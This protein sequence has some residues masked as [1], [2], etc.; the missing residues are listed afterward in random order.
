M[1]SSGQ[2]D[3]GVVQ[4]VAEWTPFTGWKSW[5][6][7]PEPVW[8]RLRLR[9]GNGDAQLP[10]IAHLRPAFLDKLTLY[11]PSA[12]LIS[13]AGDTVPMTD[14]IMGAITFTFRVPELAQ[15]RELY[16]RVASTSARVVNADVLTLSEARRQVRL[17]EWL[18]GFATSMSFIFALWAAIHWW[19]SRERV[20]GIFAIKQV[21]AVLWGVFTLGFARVVFDGIAA[22]GVISAINNTLLAGV[23]VSATWFMKNLF[24]E[25]RPKRLWTSAMTTLMVLAPAVLLLQF[26]DRHWQSVMILNLLIPITLGVMFMSLTTTRGA[27]GQPTIRRR[28]LLAYL[29]LYAVLN[30]IPPLT[31]LGILGQ[32]TAVDFGNLAYLLMDG[33]VMVVIL[34]AR[35]HAL[36]L[37]QQR[38]EQALVVSEEQ[39]RLVRLHSEDQGQL[40]AMLAHEV[41]TPLA[42]MRMW[43]DAGPLNR[44]AIERAIADMNR[45]IERCV[46]TGQLG[47]QGLQPNLQAI[48]AQALSQSV[49]AAC[50]APERVDLLA[51]P[52]DVLLTSDPH[53]LSIVLAN[54]LDNACKYGASGSRITI[55]LSAATNADGQPGWC[56]DVSNAQGP[57][58]APEVDK[59][60]V[61]YYRGKQARRQSGSGLG[62]FLI[63]NLLVLLGGEISHAP[64]T[65]EVV[66]R[67]W[68]PA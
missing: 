63:R 55:V 17:Q 7:G 53:M 59:L 2:A 54:L 18:Y 24:A 46:H 65:G 28:W 60:F 27:S 6:Y 47:D 39:A 43:M 33:M 36:A 68:L 29:A 8:I 50:R 48:H 42:T 62:L 11:D 57:A 56:W 40:L 34:H 10:W 45:V 37:R 51:P 4:Q 20:I 9:A 26:F 21:F 23:I 44:D 58:G 15:P 12:G 30:S 16:L 49:I 19:L 22:P 52:D 14:E 35:A 25:Y 1:D 5:G 38:V 32:N 13:H 3:L 67:V 66:F 64:R 61:K 31:Y 41:K